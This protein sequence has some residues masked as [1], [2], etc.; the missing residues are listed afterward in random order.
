MSWDNI[1]TFLGKLLLENWRGRKF[2]WPYLRLKICIYANGNLVTIIDK[3]II[4]KTVIA[5]IIMSLK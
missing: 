3:P 2:N 1:V 4:D 5:T